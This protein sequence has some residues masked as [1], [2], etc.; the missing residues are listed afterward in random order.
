MTENILKL[1]EVKDNL[2]FSRTKNKDVS[3]GNFDTHNI[4]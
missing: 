1:P 4:I 3:L 2:I